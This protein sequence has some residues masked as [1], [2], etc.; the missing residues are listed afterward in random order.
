MSIN[1]KGLHKYPNERENRGLNFKYLAEVKIQEPWQIKSENKDIQ[2]KILVYMIYVSF[3]YVD[4]S[5]ASKF[6]DNRRACVNK[7]CLWS[8]KPI[9]WYTCKNHIECFC[10]SSINAC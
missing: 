10:C 2:K 4:D 8:W 5:V 3:I 7:H 1:L 6:H 9:L